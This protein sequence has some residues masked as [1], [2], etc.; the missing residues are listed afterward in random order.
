MT[1]TETETIEYKK[2]L[3]ELK[4]GLISIVAILNKHKHG[5]LWFGIRNDGKRSALRPMKRP[6]VKFPI[7]S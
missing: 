5:E 3:A 7:S 1:K 4:E 6:C 2:S